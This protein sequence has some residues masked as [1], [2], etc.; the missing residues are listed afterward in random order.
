M[1]GDCR[2]EYIEFMKIGQPKLFERKMG[3]W[4]VMIGSNVSGLP[5]EQCDG[6]ESLQ[7]AL[8]SYY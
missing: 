4:K 6:Q 1:I 8:S 2:L 3:S 5:Y 7:D